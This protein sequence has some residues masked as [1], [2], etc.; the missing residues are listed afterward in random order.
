MRLGAGSFA[1]KLKRGLCPKTVITDG[2]SSKALLRAPAS[3][4]GHRQ[5]G[6]FRSKRRDA[7]SAGAAGKCCGP[8]LSE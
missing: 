4:G 3:G 6:R 2:R 1:G 7:A 5:N 8:F